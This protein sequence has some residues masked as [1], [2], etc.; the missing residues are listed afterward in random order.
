[1]TSKA[2]TS[3][4]SSKHQYTILVTSLWAVGHVNACTGALA[5]LLRRGRTRFVFLLEG[6]FE[7]KVAPLGFEEHIVHFP[8][9]K[10]EQ[11][12]GEVAAKLLLESKVIGNYSFTEK[13]ESLVAMQQGE[14]WLQQFAIYNGAIEEALRL[15]KPDLIFLDDVTL[16]PAIHYSGIPWIKNVSTVWLTI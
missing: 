3:S 1:M 4:R 8:K 7:G 14:K 11:N 15:Y 5:P 9:G 16:Y 10:D 2:S 13:F 6:Q 12:A